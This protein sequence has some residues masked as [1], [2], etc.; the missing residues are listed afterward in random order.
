MEIRSRAPSAGERKPTQPSA[1]SCIAKAE[2]DAA[3]RGKARRGGDGVGR[4]SRCGGRERRFVRVSPAPAADSLVYLPQRRRG[5]AALRCCPQLQRHY[6]EPF[7]GPLRR[8]SLGESRWERRG[9]RRD[10]GSGRG[11]PGPPPE[12][13]RLALFRPDP[14]QDYLLPP[15]SPFPARSF[16][17]GKAALA[18]GKL[19]PAGP[20]RNQPPC[21]LDRQPG[22]LLPITCNSFPP[23]PAREPRAPDRRAGGSQ[24]LNNAAASV[25]ESPDKRERGEG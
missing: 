23:P 10:R 1:V 14:L 6:Q 25:N 13:R 4:R 5:I 8:V 19:A 18:R 16:S 21:P 17:P 11:F 20:S 9:L 22:P 2:P 15:P 3:Q 12:A 24:R 7:P